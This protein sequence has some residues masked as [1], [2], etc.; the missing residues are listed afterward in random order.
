LPVLGGSEEI[1]LMSIPRTAT[2]DS[3]DPA[4]LAVFWRLALVYV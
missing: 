2:F 4:A 3:A 1:A